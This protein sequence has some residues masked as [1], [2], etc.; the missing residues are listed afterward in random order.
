VSGTRGRSFA[1]AVLLGAWLSQAGAQAIYTCVDSKGRRLTAD[2]PIV[3]CIDREQKELNPSGTVKR[4]LPPS[5]T[6]EER[7]AEEERARQAQQERN[8]LAEE[9]RRTRALVA[10]Y[11]HKAAHDKERNEA[12]AAVDVVIVTANRRLVTLQ[13][14]RQRL[15][16]ELEFYR[17]DPARIPPLLKRQIE[18]NERQLAEQRRF[19]ASQNGEKDRVNARFDEEL[20]L[21]RQLWVSPE[22]VKAAAALKAASGRAR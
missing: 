1:A 10:R 13:A 21:L 3:D 12:L 9:K 4:K 19:I 11:P 7:A 6:L 14:E 20:A 16:T 8:R 22:P 15:D 5:P 17:K 18:E 2:R